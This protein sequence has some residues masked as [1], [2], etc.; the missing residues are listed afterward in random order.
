MPIV[1]G[2]AFVLPQPATSTDT[3]HPS[4]TATA[5]ARIARNPDAPVA[6]RDRLRARIHPDGAD[7]PARRSVDSGDG[8]VDRP[9]HPDAARADGDTTRAAAD[10]NAPHDPIRDR[11]DF[12][13]PVAELVR[14]PYRP[15]ACGHFGGRKA[16]AD[17]RDNPVPARVDPPE[18]R[19]ARVTDHPDSALAHGD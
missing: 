10:W 17:R 3:T 8:M 16:E 13:K 11:V 6:D 7:D 19:V 2:R 15:L 9:G 18:R 5:L 1:N 12:D 4:V 14:D